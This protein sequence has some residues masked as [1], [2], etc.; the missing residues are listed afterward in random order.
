[1]RYYLFMD[2]SG[3][4][5]L[6]YIDRNFPI[7]LLCGCIVAEED[8]KKIEAS[9]KKLKEEFFG[10][11]GVV[12]HSRDI[13][14][15]EGAF[16]VLFDLNIKE[17][18]YKELNRVLVQSKFFLIGSGV[19]KEKHV[20]KYGRIAADPYTLSLSFVLER[21]VFCLDREDAN[22]AVEILVEQR[23]RK[24]DKQLLAHFNSVM[25]MGTYYVTSD[26][27][28]NRIRSLHFHSKRDNVIGLQVADLCAYPM[29][30]HLLNPKEPYIPFKVIENKIYRKA[31]GDYMGWGIKMFP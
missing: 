6:S 9:I 8:L 12:L 18:F 13:R 7:F 5:G 1:M 10:T 4:H 16:Q 31:S 14:K 23:G 17:Q 26:R 24:E 29:A 27:F 25:D 28:K 2:E 19:D 20:K 21:M 15:C 11:T 22:A 30:R 3:D